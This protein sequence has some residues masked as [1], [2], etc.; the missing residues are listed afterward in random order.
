[1]FCKT[2]PSAPVSLILYQR[3]SKG[4]KLDLASSCL[5]KRNLCKEERLKKMH[6]HLT[7]SNNLSATKFQF[8]FLHSRFHLLAHGVWWVPII[9]SHWNTHVLFLNISA[10]FLQI[11]IGW[12]SISHGLYF[13][14]HRSLWKL[15]S[16]S[17]HSKHIQFI[18]A[19]SED[20]H[21]FRATQM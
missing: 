3:I 9:H 8:G 4:S 17:L 14:Y 21:N 13:L 16:K 20:I 6:S 19:E 7:I 12:V 5:T 10:Y 15:R 18:S 2:L 11:F 1:M